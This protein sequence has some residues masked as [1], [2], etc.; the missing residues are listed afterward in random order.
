L[1]PFE[2]RIT[3]VYPERGPVVTIQDCTIKWNDNL[4]LLMMMMMKNNFE[5]LPKMPY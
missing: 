1:V 5:T 4:L 2:L 3:T